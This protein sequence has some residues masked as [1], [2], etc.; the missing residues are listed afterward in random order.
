LHYF[1]LLLVPI[2]IAQRT[3]GPIWLVPA[4]FWL[5]PYEEHFG[6][7]WRIGVGI[8]VAALALVAAARGAARPAYDSAS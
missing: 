8:G 2:A 3:F 4:L 1:V 6:E 7:H 5:T